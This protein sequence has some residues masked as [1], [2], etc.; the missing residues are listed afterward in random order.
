MA[1]LRGRQLYQVA[2]FACIFLKDIKGN[3]IIAG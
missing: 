3:N 1:A 2:F